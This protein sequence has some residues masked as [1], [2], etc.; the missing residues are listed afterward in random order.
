MKNFGFTAL[1]IV[2][3]HPPVWDEVVS[4]VHADE[5]LRQAQVVASL[6]EAVADCTWVVG[7]TDRRRVEPKQPL[8][9]PADLSRDMHQADHRL[10]LVFGSEK[11]GL[12]NEEL[13]YCHR[14]MTIPTQ[15]DCPSMNLGQA[16]AICCYELARDQAPS[17]H[18]DQ[19]IEWA[20]A[21]QIETAVQLMLDVL[22]LSHFIDAGR[23]A[24][25]TLKLRRAL[26]RLN[27]TKRDVNTF[28][29][30]LRK[31][32]EGLTQQSTLP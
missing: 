28:C 10:A 18:T 6:A 20:T 2:A 14:V 25:F 26:F 27:M 15:P 21:G 13:S 31:I 9:T 3:P 32:K 24:D 11:H 16:V 12:T 1:V 17:V 7:T 29:G 30:A 8:Y 19:Q 4:A 23:R 22:C 5:I